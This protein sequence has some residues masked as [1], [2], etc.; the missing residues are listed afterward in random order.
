LQWT[1]YERAQPSPEQVSTLLARLTA[2]MG[3]GHVGSPKLVDTWKPGAF[4]MAAFTVSD[5]ATADTR[6]TAAT[7][8]TPG[9]PSIPVA[10]GT[11][12]R[13]FRLPIPARVHMQD[14][15][16]ARVMV[17]RRGI[18]GGGVEQSAGP[19]RTS[20]EWWK[21]GHQ[22]WDRDEW[23]VRLNG[24]AAYRIFVERA[25]GQWFVEGMID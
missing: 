12:L 1:L 14:G 2:L 5:S 13:R 24:G 3:E 20:G 10:P 25:I 17:D 7:P 22:T 21:E 16:P 6:G 23:D 18:S 11:A 19:W 9:T 8:S 4:E 15:R